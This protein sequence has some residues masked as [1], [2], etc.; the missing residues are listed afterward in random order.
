[1]INSGSAGPLWLGTYDAT[2][3]VMMVNNTMGPQLID[4]GAVVCYSMC[5]ASGEQHDGAAADRLRCSG[6]L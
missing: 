3:E 4:S 1:M 2:K 6:V 5:A